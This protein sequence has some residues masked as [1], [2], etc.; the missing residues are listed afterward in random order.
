MKVK[1]LFLL[2]EEIFPQALTQQIRSARLH[3]KVLHTSARKIFP[4]WLR[5]TT[6][7]S[8]CYSL[9][10]H[11]DEWGHAALLQSN[12]L[13]EDHGEMPQLPVYPALAPDPAVLLFKAPWEPQSNSIAQ[14]Q[15]WISLFFPTHSHKNHKFPAFLLP[16]HIVCRV[17]CP[18]LTPGEGF[19]SLAHPCRSSSCPYLFLIAV[20]QDSLCCVWYFS[21]YPR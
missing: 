10:F 9:S 4:L 2:S 18:S 15:A 16:F 5:E 3:C 14:N 13:E 20:G 17:L 1:D 12:L 19:V 11:R 6:A 21:F 7:A 8:P